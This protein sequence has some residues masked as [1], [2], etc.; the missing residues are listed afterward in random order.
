[1]LPLELFLLHGLQL[2]AQ[3]G[4]AGG[5]FFLHRLELLGRGGPFVLARV[6]KPI[7]LREDLGAG[8]PAAAAK[9][10][11]ALLLEFGLAPDFEVP[12]LTALTRNPVLQSGQ[13]PGGLLEP[14]DEFPDLPRIRLPRRPGVH[15]VFRQA[16][17]WRGLAPSR[18]ASDDR[19]RHNAQAGQP[20]GL[21]E[22][23]GWSHD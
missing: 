22:K 16:G 14:P 11:A 4:E 20:Q 15:D 9:L 12:D 10:A 3:W 21:S 8:F 13:R 7:A 2:L 18:C 23:P 5:V 17:R 6:R 19:D 1:M